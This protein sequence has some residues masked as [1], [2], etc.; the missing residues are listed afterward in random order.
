MSWKSTVSLMFSKNRL[1]HSVQ[2]RIFLNRP[3]TL[4]L[5]CYCI[6]LDLLHMH[7]YIYCHMIVTV[8]EVLSS[9]S[10]LLEHMLCHLKFPTRK[11]VD[12]IVSRSSLYFGFSY[13]LLALNSYSSC[14]THGEKHMLPV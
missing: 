9:S 14:L 4:L 11:A 2:I 13:T 10:I 8:C 12:Y 6:Y 7:M 1:F 5:S 3:F